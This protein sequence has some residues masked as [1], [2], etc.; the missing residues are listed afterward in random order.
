MSGSTRT[1]TL[2]D[3]HWGTC[4]LW[5]TASTIAGQ[6]PPGPSLR[7]HLPGMGLG[8]DCHGRGP[9]ERGIGGGYVIITELQGVDM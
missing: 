7:F 2:P 9:G 5:V 4:E 1:I 6:G 8:Q 3:L